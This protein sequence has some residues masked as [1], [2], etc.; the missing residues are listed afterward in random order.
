MDI[1]LLLIRLTV[2][3]IIAAH[4][5]QKLLGAFGGHG[6]PGTAGFLE[7]LGFR[8]GRPYAWLLGTAEAVGGLLL[9]LG[10]LT[11]V[12]AAAVTGVMVTAI[13]VVHWQKGF[14]AQDG[15]YEFP[16]LLAVAA[17]AVAF[18]GPGQYSLDQALDWQLAGDSWA[19][20]AAALGVLV[21]AATAAS[22][23]HRLPNWRGRRSATA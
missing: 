13:A 1:G 20:A 3:G 21:S 16:L 22:R 17:I 2:G 19:V 15:G 10:F 8:P 6:I 14:F 7:S 5:A 4:G 9:A 23:N 18:A 12:G 11:P